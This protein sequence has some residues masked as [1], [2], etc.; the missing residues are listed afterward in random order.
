[1][2]KMITKKLFTSVLFVFLVIGLFAQKNNPWSITEESNINKQNAQ[3][4]IVPSKY[5]T[6]GL[7]GIKLRSVLKKTPLRFSAAAQSSPNVLVLPMPGGDFE[8]F[9]IV[10]ASVM[11]PEL[12]AKYPNMRSFAGKG[13]DDPTAYLR[14]SLTQKGFNAMVMSAN[15]STVYIDPYLKGDTQFYVCYYKKDYVKDQSSP[16]SCGVETP[17]NDFI[18]KI[19]PSKEQ[20]ILNNQ[21]P[22]FIA[23]DCQLRTYR[24]ALACTGEYASFHG[25][26]V[27]AV[28]AEYVIAMTRVNG[29]Y[30]NDVTVTMELV[31]NTDQII[32]LN[33]ATDP[34]TNG[35]GGAMLG[36][37]QT[38]CDNVIGSANYDIG[39]V[40]STGG[41]GVA[42]LAVP[43]T[44]SKARGVTGLPSPVGDPFYID[45]V[46]HE[47]GHQFGANHTQ[48][49]SCNR[50]NSTAMEPGSASTIMGYAGI[51][52]PNVQNN[53]DDHF[54]AISIQEITNNIENGNSSGCP[55][56]TNTGN[57]SPSASVAS[58]FYN[59]PVSTPFALT[60][61]ASDPDDDVLTYNWEQMDNEVAP[62]PPISSNTGG[63]AFRSNSSS[64]SP[65]RY[66]PNLNA[67]INNTT[68]T[69]E[70]IPSVSRSMDFR[71][72]VRDNFMGA[73]CRDEVDV[74]LSF[75]SS[76]GP[77]LV[78]NPN[79]NLTWTVSSAETIVWNVANT[80]AAPV[81]CANVDIL[82]SLDGGFTYP[83]ILAS[84]VPNTGN[85]G[86][87]VP[88]EPSTTARV[89]VVCSDNIFFDISD[90]DFVIELPANPTFIIE[91]SPVSQS[92]CNTEDLVYNIDLTS[93]LGFNEEVT[94]S[95]IGLP[96]AA[97]AT[98]D[99][100]PLVPPGNVQLTIGNLSEVPTG[101][102]GLIINAESSSLN[103]TLDIEMNLTDGIPDILVL[104]TPL[105]GATGV[106]LSA[107][108]E[109]TSSASST[110][111]FIEI[112]TS[113]AFGNS[114]IETSTVSS[115]S[116][117]AQN[118]QELTVYYWRVK[119][120]NI[121]GE[122][123]FSN[124]FAFQTTQTA[125][126]TYESLDVPIPISPNQVNTVSSV[127]NVGDDFNLENVKCNL[128]IQH[129][130]LGDLSA[131][132]TSPTTS[133]ILLFDQPG[134]PDSQFGCDGNDV[135]AT[136]DDDAPNSAFD[137]ENTCE[138]SIP[139]ILGNFQP[140]D[141]LSTFNGENSFGIWT[142]TVHDDFAEDGGAINSWSIELC[143]SVVLPAM[144]DLITNL[145]L[146]VPNG[147]NEIITNAYL[148][149]SSPSNSA[150]QIIFTIISLPL[151]GAL[152]LEIGGTP[153]ILN[154]GDQ[155]SQEDINNDFLS[156]TH[157]GSNTVSDS[158]DFDVVNNE[159]GWL[160]GST[161]YINIVENNL[162][163]SANLDND[164]DCFN[165]NNGQVSV[166][167]NGGVGPF[168]YSIDGINFQSE[169]IFENLSPGAYTFTVKDAND[170]TAT[171]N[172]IMINNPD[173]LLIDADVV[174]DDITLNASGG[175]GDLIFSIDGINF[176]INNV[177]NDLPNGV[178][179][180]YVMDEN[181]CI[182]QTEVIIAVN[183]MIVSAILV[184]DLDC[185]NDSNAS[186]EVSVGGGTPDFTFSLNGGTF[187]S[188]NVFDGLGVGSYIITVM[189][190]DGFTAE[191]NEII[192]INPTELTVSVVVL[193]NDIT[194]NA[195]GGTGDLTYSIDGVNY[196]SSNIFNDLA[197]GTY[198]VYV[199][200]ENGCIIE[201]EATI[202]VNNLAV[203]ATLVNGIDCFNENDASIEVNVEGGTP[204][205]TYSLNG[206][207]FQSSNI[208]DDLAAGN[209]IVT[210]MDNDGFTA[211]TNEI[212]IN[213]PPQLTASVDI[214]VNDIT[215]NASGGT[216]SLTYSIDGVNFQSSNMFNDLL[217]GEH[218]IY[219]MDSNGCVIEMTITILDNTLDV[220]ATLVNG[221]DC[222]NDMNASIEV[223]VSGGTPDFTYSLNGSLFQSSNIFN[224]LGA[225]TYTIIVK[226]ANSFTSETNTII[227]E[228]PLQITGFSAVDGYDITMTASG[229]TGDLQYSL[230]GGPFQSSN[231]FTGNPN[232]IYT[233][234]IMD[235]NGCQIEISATVNV[236]ALGIT[237][238]HQRPSCHDVN[239]GLILIEASGGEPP[240]QYSID[241][242]NFQDENEF[243]GLSAGNY[244]VTVMDSGGFTISSGSIIITNP[245]ELTLDA[246]YDTNNVTL[247]AEGGTPPYL[248]SI[249]GVTFG[250]DNEFNNLENGEY[251]FYVQDENGCLTETTILIDITGIRD[252]NFD[253]SLNVSPNPGNGIFVI[254]IKQK[255]ASDLSFK[256]FDV[257]GKLVYVDE[258]QL[259]T[260]EIEK[261]ID[262]M[263][264]PSATYHLVVSNEQQIGTKKLVIL[265]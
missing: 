120:I 151:N 56:I 44:N 217:A 102:Y 28:M 153:T 67:I 90:Q 222:Y 51:C 246:I 163:A 135:L 27:P 202:L 98:F 131:E 257:V 247:N 236:N 3:R 264:L 50:N 82:L 103:L 183:T 8:R 189:D 166:T 167:A 30:E 76:A 207:T 233:I 187:Q 205:F 60:C 230:N 188:S 229:G 169:N 81:S 168:E 199:M 129:T 4:D 48:N 9:E 190:N 83:I 6:V 34:Y 235:E 173:E 36:Q 193:E 126:T 63:P 46:A 244:I 231:I 164:I 132:L 31:P 42:N 144:P 106:E 150:D 118:L 104:N 21:S 178:Y 226:D 22:S 255:E 253:L 172:E 84:E 195:S 68:P 133:S 10:E 99:N 148:E 259:S 177:F 79:T 114:I 107:L 109:W 161:F 156:Y 254:A 43:C 92:A 93:I 124:A 69:W 55:V 248:Y 218:T 256:V 242:I 140:I 12:Q 119:G 14:F 249:D 220:T 16:F 149:A 154:I 94:L 174:D 105:D 11:H 29:V 239:D 15:H 204:D 184:N 45:Y 213:N 116:H 221:L 182:A 75:H 186:I 115:N 77:F 112:A 100:N 2:K 171:T 201:T 87:I 54:H 13:I 128:F 234:T 123:E 26:N 146:T 209:Y 108:L 86:I 40:F 101:I 225:G 155:F 74:D 176:Q 111:Y 1:M 263:H 65:T 49:N 37:N 59:L 24:L 196:Q 245:D 61:I 71:C 185:Y 97:T 260:L 206:G 64:E 95:V 191:T 20:E 252:L 72:T 70:V 223:N 162:S 121:C 5:L 130:W 125:C 194:I 138:A 261:T 57:S 216:G 58:T 38:T 62:M 52:A 96:G 228:N 215:V 250:P 237:T 41:G 122:G 113:P 35:S 211:E 7:D 179:T 262:L 19:K 91:V 141:P 243:G 127:I 170:L 210:V 212:I 78:V 134:V 39:H 232:G 17:E 251:T 227:V 145:E 197:N 110:N 85:Y 200:D 214:L 32:Y 143:G 158:F 181:G 152:W 265:K 73:G 241:G 165:A 139:T 18:K 136:F 160:H 47:M 23:G 175:T 203:T 159:N 224:G 88:N 208:F 198:T 142:L 157:D 219:V 53:S 25:G 33:A 137:F 180:V 240:Y 147:A 80:N 238:T 258:L 89:K 66:F 192:I 117:Q